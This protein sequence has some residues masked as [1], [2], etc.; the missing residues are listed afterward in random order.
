MG[1]SRRWA[2]LSAGAVLVLVLFLLV[3]FALEDTRQEVRRTLCV[4]NMKMLAMALD[5]YAEEHEGRLPDSISELYPKYIYEME[6]FICPEVQ[7]QCRRERGL[8]HPFSQEPS[9]DEIDRLSSY[10]LVPDLSAGDD[11]DTVL[12]FEKEDNHSGMGRSV[13][14]LDGCGAWEPPENWRNG[15]PNANLPQNF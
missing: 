7:R 15:P 6:V 8:T 3:L 5:Q 2:F 10:I 11:A 9:P 1:M 4:H 14:Y 13:L 12:A